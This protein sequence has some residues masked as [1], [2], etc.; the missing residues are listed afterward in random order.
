MKNNYCLICGKEMKEI[1]S[2]GEYKYLKCTCCNWYSTEM[3]ESNN[4][5]KFDYDEY[6]TFDNSIENFDELVQDA[7][8]IL[9]YKFN[10]LGRIPSSFLDI[11]TSEGVFVKAYNNISG[12][13]NGCGIEVSKPKI[14]R[15]KERG[16]NVVHFDD[17]DDK[18][19][20]F[21]LLRHVI[22][23]IEDPKSYLK[24]ISK[25]LSP[26]GVLCVETPNNDCWIQKIKGRHINDVSRGKYVRELY[27]PVHVCGFTPKS[28]RKI[29]GGCGLIADLLVTYDNSNRHFVYSKDASTES[30]PIYRKVF[31]KIQIGPNIMC[32]FINGKR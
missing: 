1:A 21:I 11:G 23:H 14:E 29:G 2:N 22:E 24:H 25:W 12:T 4:K 19:Y 7:E 16:L 13:K 3:I 18:K 5:E 8:G 28:L 27:P 9:R 15:A 17:M 6:E 20:D 32:F 10:L 26:D 31:E 30:V